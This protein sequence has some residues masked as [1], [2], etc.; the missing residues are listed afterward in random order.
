MQLALGYT[1]L[2]DLPL[3]KIATI[4]QT[5][6]SSVFSWKKALYFD[7]NFAS[8]FVPTGL[9]TISQIGLGIG[10][11]PNRRQGITLTNADQFTDA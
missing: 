5:T 3:Y 9:L 10:L 4:S 7:L 2:A 1:E 11:V 6:F 8:S